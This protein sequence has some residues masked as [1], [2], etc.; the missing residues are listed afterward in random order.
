MFKWFNKLK[1]KKGFT[2]I[3]LIVVLAV[4]GIIA[5]IAVPRFLNVQENSRL[6]SDETAAA[7][8]AK[9]AELWYAQNDSTATNV[10]LAA[11]QTANLVDDDIVLQ[12]EDFK[13]SDLPETAITIAY[14]S[15]TGIVT[16]TLDAAN[17]GTD[18]VYPQP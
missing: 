15:T 3:E 17:S 18:I 11:L 13:T 2:L 1:N 5:L 9:A 10:S 16:V 14:D 4:L 8:I 12:S 7:S 6:S